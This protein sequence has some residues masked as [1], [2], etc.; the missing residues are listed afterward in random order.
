MSSR[1][2]SIAKPTPFLSSRLRRK[3]DRY[4]LAR[5]VTL[6]A[7]VTAAVVSADEAKGDIVYSGVRNI[8]IPFND[9]AGIYFDFDTGTTS[10][11]EVANVSDLNL[12]DAYSTTYAN[13]ST[14]F[15]H[16]IIFLGP[17]QHDNAISAGSDYGDLTVRL[18]IGQVIGPNQNFGEFTT[19]NTLISQYYNYQNHAKTGPAKGMWATGGSGYVGFK[20]ADKNGQVDYGWMRVQLNLNNFFNDMASA[21]VIDWAYNNTGGVI[22]A[23]QIPEPSSVALSLLGGGALGLAIWRRLRNQKKET[24]EA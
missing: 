13:E 12:F 20:F 5:S 23:G 16:G 2:C 24:P 7:T 10:T 18:Q 21:T 14:Y 8:S 4:F 17:N 9:F 15:Y 11:K 6:G 22:A 3:L 19:A 1:A